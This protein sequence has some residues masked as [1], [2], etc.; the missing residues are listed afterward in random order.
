MNDSNSPYTKKLNEIISSYGL[1]Q[2]VDVP[3]HISGNTLDVV[4]SSHK[5][6]SPNTTSTDPNIK[7]IHPGCD[8][9][10]INFS[11]KDRFSTCNSEKKVISFRNIK[12]INS[13]D[14]RSDLITVIK[15]LK[16]TDHFHDVV[17]LF[18]NK[19]NVL[20]DNYAPLITKTI[21]DRSTAPWFDGE[22]KTLRNKRRHAEKNWRKTNSEL[23]RAAYVDLRNKCNELAL[24]KKKQFYMEQFKKNNYS[25]KSLYKFVDSFTDREN[26]SVLPPNESL[27]TTVDNFS[28]FFQEK[29]EKIREKFPSPPLSSIEPSVQFSGK[30]L[31]I[32]R[33]TTIDEITE[34]LQD[35]G[36]KTS[37]F[38][39]LPTCLI[40][41]N[42]DILTPWLCDVVNLS[43]S[44]GSIDGVKLSHILPNIKDPIL[45]PS[46]LKN[47]RPIS[48]LALI[49]KLTEKIVLKL[50]N[51]HLD[52]NNLH[53]PFQSGY[54]PFHST[55]TLLVKIVDDLL[56]AADQQKATVVMMLDLSAAFDTVD[57]D[58]LLQVLHSEIGIAGTALKWFRSFITGRH[59]KVKIGTSESKEI[60]I[61]FGVPQGS[62]LG[63]VFFNLYI[64]SFL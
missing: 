55:E 14:F 13:H 50:L 28:D 62:V 25:P 41:D 20:L 51:E 4:I 48:N 53:I 60:P 61:K 29:I 9:F 1:I 30:W 17:Q 63:P 33:P 45:D 54:K 23:D 26:S 44:S 43:L 3:T 47:Y 57:H 10:P 35:S 2:H 56:I 16:H 5:V 8:H 39:P 40:K 42:L 49:S 18:N 59:Q 37:S 64:R 34:V 38:D 27:Q 24:Q 6:V 11:F 22:Y 15:P 31:N 32:F 46:S 52:Q 19:C 7:Q 12:A 36:V 58:K 21:K